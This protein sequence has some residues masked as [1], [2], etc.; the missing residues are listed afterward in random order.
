M[1]REVLIKRLQRLRQSSENAADESAET[2]Q[3]DYEA[4]RKHVEE[5]EA[6][7]SEMYK[8]EELKL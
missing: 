3:M 7:A 5:Q 2:K 8:D 1:D 4:L 6:A